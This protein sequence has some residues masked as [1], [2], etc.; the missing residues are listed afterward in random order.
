MSLVIALDVGTQSSRA[1]AYDSSGEQVGMGQQ[2]H[3]PLTVGAAGAV[4]QCPKDVW[5]ALQ[6]ALRQ[7][8]AELGDRGDEVQALA[9]TTQRYTMIPCAVDGAP[10]MDAIHWLDRRV[11]DISDHWMLKIAGVV[12]RLRTIFSTAR[13]RVL[14]TVAPDVFAQTQRFLPMSAWLG[15][16]LTGF[17]VDTPGSFP[18]MWPMDG[19]SGAWQT[20]GVLY[21]LLSIDRD[22]LPELVPAGGRIGVLRQS[23]ADAVG[24]AAGLPL[25]AVGGDKQAEMLGSGAVVGD[26]GV[27]AISLG[28]A[29]S[30]TTLVP[31]F[32]QDYSAKIYTTAAAEP[33]AWC[34]EYMVNRGM[35]MVTWLRREW[36]PDASFADLER[37][38]QGID[39]GADGL[40]VIPRWGA[41]VASAHER[42][43]MLGFSE[44]HG[45][46]HVYRAVI[47]GI[48]MDLRRGLSLLERKIG[49][50]LNDLRVGGGGAQS[51]WVVQTL[52]S[53]L[54][55][56]LHRGRTQELSALGAAVNAAVHVGW[57]VDHAAAAA[58]MT[59]GGCVIQP[60]SSDAAQYSRLYEE[61]FLP[62]MTAT[63]NLHR[64][65]A[66]DVEKV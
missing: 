4:T 7:C 61:R 2:A 32:S 45:R 17:A 63:G 25:V 54:G 23:A 11:G 9:L 62:R 46:G 24:L 1:I 64:R 16:Q 3:P 40:T 20:G 6:E 38:A 18:G 41:P 51:D 36:M 53:V 34:L 65:E 59:T 12:P 60:N 19:K 47:E 26:V 35:W 21:E 27:A 15:E 57:Y 28:T 55:R 5:A 56:P 10:L 58:A 13:G 52:A 48:C 30:V 49:R 39:P 50:P 42:G 22:W 14:Q 29:A 43:A 37:A 33:G 66:L 31:K 8:V 44:M